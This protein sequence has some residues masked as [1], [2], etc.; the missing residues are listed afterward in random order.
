MTSLQKALLSNGIFSCASGLLAVLFPQ[1]IANYLGIEEKIPVMLIGAS[2][3][4]FSIFLFWEV[5]KQRKNVVIGIVILDLIW[6]LGTVIILTLNPFSIN[7]EGLWLLAILG[8]VVL[9]LAA[10]QFISNSRMVDDVTAD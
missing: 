7:T 3:I 9:V 5:G 4:L 10:V 6:V 8:V 2:L 1:N